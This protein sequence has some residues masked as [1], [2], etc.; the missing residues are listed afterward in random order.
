LR[1]ESPTI[2]QP[3]YEIERNFSSKP[4]CSYF[5]L[6]TVKSTDEVNL[7]IFCPPVNPS[8]CLL[9]KKNLILTFERGQ[10]SE[11]TK[12]L[13]F[14][15]LTGK[16]KSGLGR[17][18]SHKYPAGRQPAAPRKREPLRQGTGPDAVFLPN[19]AAETLA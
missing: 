4:G 14:F 13:G 1:P 15:C 18:I 5:G 17:P 2:Q 3:I 8:Q 10:I 6:P 11:I 12:I 19:S 7:K 9:Q 16:S